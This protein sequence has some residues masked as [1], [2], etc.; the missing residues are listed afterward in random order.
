MQPT[1][2]RSFAMLA[3][4]LK[5]ASDDFGVVTVLDAAVEGPAIDGGRLGQRV[6]LAGRWPA[7]ALFC[8]LLAL[9]QI[10]CEY[11]KFTHV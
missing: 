8:S 5:L 9:S 1:S 11:V 2:A 3:R 10:C 7:L 6:A 4:Q